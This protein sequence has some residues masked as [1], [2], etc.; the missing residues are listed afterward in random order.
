MD[1]YSRFLS[2]SK[3]QDIESLIKNPV[4]HIHNGNIPK[5][6]QE[7][8]YSMLLNLASVCNANSSEILWGFISK[9]TEDNNNS[10]PLMNNL[11]KKALQYYKDFI[12]PNKKY[13][14]PNKNEIIALQS[15]NKRL[16]KLKDLKRL[17]K[18]IDKKY[19][20]YITDIFFFNLV[21]PHTG[22]APVADHYQWPALLLSEW[23]H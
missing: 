13:K 8:S 14:N 3:N 1:E 9:Y 17:L 20:K 19:H 10:D 16:I 5:H 18:I 7:I 11:I 23:G 22:Y 12:A 21:V 15:L 2:S 6:N 4:W